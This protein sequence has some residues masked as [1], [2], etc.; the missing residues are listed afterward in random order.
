MYS[1]SIFGGIAL[2]VALLLGGCAKDTTSGTSAS[3]RGDTSLNHQVTQ[4]V[5]NVQG[6]GS[7]DLNVSTHNGTVT[8][9]GRTRTRAQAQDA[10][11]AARQ[12]PGVKTVDYDIQVDDK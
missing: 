12:V 9:R 5:R 4:A 10:I 3:H 8:L 2:A 1:K 11:E 7:D 6:V